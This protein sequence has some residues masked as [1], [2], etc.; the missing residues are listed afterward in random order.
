MLLTACVDKVAER[1]GTNVHIIPISY[2]L[3]LTIKGNS[4][5]DAWNELND[6]VE[7]HWDKVSSQTVKLTW[8]T[9]SGETLANAY[10]KHLLK[11]GLNRSQLKIVSGTSVE[12]GNFDV[13]FQ[14]IVHRAVTETCQYEKVG[15]F[16][17]RK[18]GCYS[19]GARWK[20][21]VNPEKMLSHQ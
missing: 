3:S 11:L 18:V 14:T 16:D 17:N 2:S 10:Y 20:S 12:D 1:T 4:V 21:M 6:Y 15:Y 8:Y 7:L 19:E 13:S 9:E 5:E